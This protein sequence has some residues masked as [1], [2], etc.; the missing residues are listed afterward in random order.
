MLCWVLTLKLPK[1]DGASLQYRQVERLTLKQTLKGI[2]NFFLGAYR[3]LA[4]C[5]WT[6]TTLFGLLLQLVGC[7][8]VKET[9]SPSDQSAIQT[10]TMDQS[11]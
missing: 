2:L 4:E 10:V 8:S 7:M 6:N 11:T 5:C 1:E 3:S 9:S